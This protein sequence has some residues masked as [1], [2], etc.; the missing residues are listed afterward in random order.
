MPANITQKVNVIN[1]L[2]PV[3]IVHNCDINRPKDLLVL[4]FKPL[5]AIINDINVNLS[6]GF[7]LTIR[8]ATSHT[9]CPASQHNPFVA[10]PNKT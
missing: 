1:I 9:S 2:E 5:N 7:V 4:T 8:V 3:I 10:R 6:P